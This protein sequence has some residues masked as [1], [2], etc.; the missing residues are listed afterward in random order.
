MG[1]HVNLETVNRRGLVARYARLRGITHPQADQFTRNWN[2]SDLRH[3]IERLEA[4]ERP[5]AGR[6][7]RSTSGQLTTITGYTTMVDGIVR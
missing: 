5:Y 3:T 2:R 6:R 4:D 1:K 7:T